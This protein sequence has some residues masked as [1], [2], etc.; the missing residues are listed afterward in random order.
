MK[1]KNAS[2]T[3]VLFIIKYLF[4]LW[5]QQPKKYMFYF[6]FSW[7]LYCAHWSVSWFGLN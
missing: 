2:F 7:L 3:N 5:E 4:L 6:C 1:A